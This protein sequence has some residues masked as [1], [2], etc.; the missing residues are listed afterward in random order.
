MGVPAQLRQWRACKRGLQKQTR[1][2]INDAKYTRVTK[3]QKTVYR[4]SEITDIGMPLPGTREIL[5][6]KIKTTD[7]TNQP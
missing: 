3:S 2:E 6:S 5:L 1:S 7:L 4:E